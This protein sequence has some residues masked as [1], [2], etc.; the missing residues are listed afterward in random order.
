MQEKITFWSGGSFFFGFIEYSVP[1]HVP[2]SYRQLRDIHHMLIF[3]SYQSG[4]GCIGNDNIFH[5][6]IIN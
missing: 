2:C 5:N 4:K 3:L 6:I 1:L